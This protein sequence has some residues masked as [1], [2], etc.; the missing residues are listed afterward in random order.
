MPQE[1][2]DLLITYDVYW[3][4]IAQPIIPSH[5]I[6]LYYEKVLSGWAYTLASIPSCGIIQV[7]FTNRDTMNV[8]S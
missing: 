4:K 6:L 5:P 8:I 2:I 3:N 1:W 7:I